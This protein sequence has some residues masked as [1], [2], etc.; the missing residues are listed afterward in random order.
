[1]RML[2]FGIILL[3]LLAGCSDGPIV[4]ERPA[5][6]DIH[7]KLPEAHERIEPF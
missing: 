3:A 2:L 1:M 7:Q 6:K 5:P 4:R